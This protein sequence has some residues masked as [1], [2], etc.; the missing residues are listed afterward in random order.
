[1]AERRSAA[2][3]VVAVE[4]AG[5]PGLALGAGLPD[6]AF[7]HDGQITKR[8]V[9]AVTLAALAPRRG[10]MLWDVGAGSG[11][12]GIE[13]M[14]LH[15]SLRAVAVEARADRAARVRANAEALG[16]PGLR[17]VEGAAPGALAGLPAPDAVFL[18]GGRR[19]RRSRRRR[20][21]C[22][23]GGRLVVECGD[24]GDAG[25]GDGVGGA[26][27]RGARDAFG[28]AGG[29]GGRDDRRGGRRCRWCSGRG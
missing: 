29:G 6:A 7:A 20:R 15:P 10:E 9:R 5:A 13:W 1:M 24:A 21:R 27:R 23:P 12:V 16:V 18:G 22:G 17:V 19:G 4:V 11:S 26:A 2:L 3:N 8:E 28:G 25:A 14:R